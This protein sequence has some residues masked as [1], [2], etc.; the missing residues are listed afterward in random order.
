MKEA[1]LARVYLGDATSTTD[2]S[3]RF[4]YVHSEDVKAPPRRCASPGRKCLRLAA[5][6]QMPGEEASQTYPR[7]EHTWRVSLSDCRPDG[8]SSSVDNHWPKEATG[9]RN[10][11]HCM[12]REKW[13]CPFAPSARS[14]LNAGEKCSFVIGHVA[15][16]VLEPDCGDVGAVNLQT[17]GCFVFGLSALATDYSYA[18]QERGKHQALIL[19][20]TRARVYDNSDPQKH[21]GMHGRQVVCP[22]PLPVYCARCMEEV[23]PRYLAGEQTELCEARVF[24]FM[25]QPACSHQAP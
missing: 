25:A 9:R 10:G 15:K 17:H 16:M 22:V 13:K 8:P 5:V 24:F 3:S 12:H 11:R 1:S 14:V 4:Q 6:H 18:G 23:L 7:S 20:I 21:E 19:D 2:T